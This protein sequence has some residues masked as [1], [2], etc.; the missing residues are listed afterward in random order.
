MTNALL[1]PKLGLTMTEGFLA[2]WNVKPGQAFKAGDSLFVVET[3]KVATEMPAEA[4]GV[5]DSIAVET[6]ATVAV[7]VI[8]GYWRS[9]GVAADA[10]A[11]T[12][13]QTKSVAIIEANPATSAGIAGA[14]PQLSQPIVAVPSTA[15]RIISTPLARRIAAERGIAIASVTGSGPRGRIKAGDIPAQASAPKPVVAPAVASAVAGRDM[16][17]G[18]SPDSIQQTTARRLTEVKQQVPHFY[19]AVDVEI[20]ALL[21]LR[22]ELN[23]LQQLASRPPFTLNHF[24]LAAVGRALADLPQAN[25]IW[26]DGKIVSFRSTDVGVA[27]NT[28]RGLLVPVLRDAGRQSLDQLGVQA[29]RL[30]DGARNGKLTLADTGGGAVTVSNAGMHQVRYMTPIIN[31]GQAMILGVGAIGSVFRPDAEGRPSLRQEMGLVLAADHRILDGVSGLTF[32][33]RVTAYLAQPMTL[34]VGVPH[35]NGE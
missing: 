19:L 3:D 31:P 2:E 14:Q 20:D 21:Q 4:D 28:D 13:P 32:L 16:G 35:S 6:G 8:V 33:S 24:V 30:V 12:P 17:I 18:S 23:A 22:K 15:G 11:A 9:T 7:G 26:A 27:V 34:L 1:M 10:S 25:R 29:R 5:L